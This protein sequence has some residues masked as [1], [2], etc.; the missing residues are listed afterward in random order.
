MEREEC[1]TD[2]DVAQEVKPLQDGE[3]RSPNIEAVA[4]DGGEEGGEQDLA[5]GRK[6]LV[7]R[8]SIVARLD[9]ADG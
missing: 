3:V 9:E 6:A 1:R 8:A 2:L 7:G 5:R 4:C